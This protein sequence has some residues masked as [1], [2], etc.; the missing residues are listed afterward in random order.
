ML[1]RM[2]GRGPAEAL[3]AAG[4]VED[5]TFAERLC[6]WTLRLWL[7]GVAVDGGHRPVLI[8]TYAKLGAPGAMPAIDAALWTMRIGGYRPLRAGCPCQEELFEDEM[9]LLLLLACEQVGAPLARRPVLD[10]ILAPAA[11]RAFGPPLARWAEA[12]ETVGLRLPLRDWPLPELTP[13]QEDRDRA[14]VALH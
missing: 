4:A 5:L 13:C 6:L 11:A 3:P 10:R 9:R 7:S 14:G 1:I 2:V 8:E 12:L